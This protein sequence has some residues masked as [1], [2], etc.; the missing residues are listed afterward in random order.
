M[1]FQEKNITVTL[2]SFSLIL[3]FYTTRVFQ[4]AADGGLNST[5]LFRLWGIV[6]VLSIIVTII[7]M[8]L[9]HIVSAIVIAI[10]TGDENP[11]IED[12]KDERDELIDLKGTKITYTVT[13][14]GSFFAMFTFVL[15]Q[16]PLV[17]FALLVFFGLMAQVIGD[18]T[19]LVIYRRGF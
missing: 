6:I 8:I 4:M 10:Q 9:T 5:D 16:S 3:I 1:S 15:G 13:S 11:D 17:M 14:L 2:I 12:I 19:R 18:V 7:G